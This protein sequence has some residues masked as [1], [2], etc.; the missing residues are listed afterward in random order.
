M[1]RR[2]FLE[3]MGLAAA[4]AALPWKFNLRQGFTSARAYAFAQT[5]ILKKFVDSLPGLTVAGAN[6]LGQYLTVLNPDTDSFPGSDYYK[7]VAGQYT[8]KVHSSLPPTTFW[9]YAQDGGPGDQAHKYLGGVIVATAN[10][11]V[12]LTMRNNLPS[13]TLV[14]VDATV[15]N[16]NG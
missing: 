2:R 14:P 10:R 9:G 11:P 3:L 5:P 13:T 6:N 1:N 4:G 15:P 16:A 12:R 8:Q 7:V